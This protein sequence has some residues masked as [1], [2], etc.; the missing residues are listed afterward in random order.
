MYYDL[1]LPWIANEVELQRTL[2][3]LAECMLFSFPMV[4]TRI[5]GY[6][7]VALNHTITGKLPVNL[8]SFLP[9][10]LKAHIYSNVQFLPSYR[11]PF[12]PD[13]T[14]SIAVLSTFPIHLRTIVWLPSFHTTIFL[15]SD[16]QLNTLSS[17]HVSLYRR[18]SYLWIFRSAFHFIS[19][20]K[21]SFRQ[22]LVASSL[23]FAI[24]QARAVESPAWMPVSPGAI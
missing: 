17:R 7:V 5:V 18:I 1:N 12:L 20:K 2:I 3:F 22:L 19:N 11:F 4:L 15:Q 13:Y 10:R 14:S 16:Q 23:K 21:P 6:N 8:V 9:R 24:L